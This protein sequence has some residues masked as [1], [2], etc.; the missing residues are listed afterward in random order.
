MLLFAAFVTGAFAACVDLPIQVQDCGKYTGSKECTGKGAGCAGEGWFSKENTSNPNQ[1]INAQQVCINRGY[2]Q[3]IDTNLFGGN[4]GHQCRVP[5]N[6]VNSTNKAGGAVTSLGYTVTWK[7][8]GSTTCGQQQTQAPTCGGDP[9][10]PVKDCGKYTGNTRECVGKGAGC[11][12]EGWFSKD[13]TSNPNQRVNAQQVCLLQGFSQGIDSQRFGGNWGH[14]CR[15]PGN[16]INSTN[17]AGGAVTQL[18]YTVTWKCLGS[19]VCGPTAPPTSPPTNA[20][21]QCK[22]VPSPVKDCGKYVGNSRECVGQ[23]AGCAGEGWFSKDNTSN[24][25]QRVNA[26]QI[27]KDQGFTNIDDARFGGNWGHQCRVPGNSL[28]STNKAGGAVTSLGYTVTWKCLGSRNCGPT[29]PPTNPPTAPPTN[30]P[31]APPSN[32][33]TAPPTNSPGSCPA[34][35]TPVMDCGKYTGSKE[36]TGKG[37]GCAGSGW[38]SKDNTSNPNQRINAQKVCTDQGYS[39]IDNQRFGGN[40]GH[41]CRIPGNSLNVANKAGGAV[42][43]LGYTVTWKCVGVQQAPCGT[44]PTKPPTAPPTNPP[45]SP[46]TYP[47]VDCKQ[48]KE[49]DWCKAG[50]CQAVTKGCKDCDDKNEKVL[51]K[52]KSGKCKKYYKKISKTDPEPC[53]NN[54]KCV[55]VLK[56]EGNESKG[57]KCTKK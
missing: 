51:K 3:G 43:S 5:G 18:G 15:V 31:T 20:G 35:A 50:F 7:C 48:R 4:W 8:K 11:A 44:T 26:Q 57:W 30:P 10:S 47:D 25:N 46:P 41:Q 19:R 45:T 38:F 28:N 52:C 23:G 42:T 12:G 13:N 49:I 34:L 56:K 54:P 6:S 29:A 1:R 24:P 40:W 17:K 36:C 37:A 55:A 21:A 27:C 2:S 33:P 22:A 39:G 14:Q 32:P 16:S 9:P 53:N